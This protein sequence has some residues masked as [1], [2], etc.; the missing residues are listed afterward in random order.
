MRRALIVVSKLALAV[1]A[2]SLAGCG[3][4]APKKTAEPPPFQG[5]YTA[6]GDCADSGKL[7]I[8]Q[9]LTAM[10]K[11]VAE[12]EKSAPS[13]KSLRSCEGTE[14]SIAANA[15]MSAITARCFS[16]SW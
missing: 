10:E 9:C 14:G 4:G 3:G 15:P 8:D 2:S 1:A 7:T 11:A 5:I 12:H 6:S 16:R 13:Y